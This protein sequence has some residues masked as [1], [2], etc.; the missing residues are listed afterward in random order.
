MPY[1]FYKVLHLLGILLLFTSLGGVAMV[2]LRGG[3]DDEKKAFKKPLMIIH[4][5]SLLVIFVA[6]FGLMARLG[7]MGNGWPTWIFGKLG[8][9]LVLGGSAALVAKRPALGTGWYLVLPAL[10]TGAAVLAVYKPG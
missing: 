9:W 1:E 7:M 8:V 3:T 4:G 5:V 10:G 2:G 6:G